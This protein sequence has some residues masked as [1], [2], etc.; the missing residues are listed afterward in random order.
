MFDL[1]WLPR[2]HAYVILQKCD[3][4]TLL[5][6]QAPRPANDMSLLDEMSKRLEAKEA[7]V[8]RLRVLNDEAGSGMHMDEAGQ[9]TQAF[10]VQYTSVILQ[11]KVRT[12]L[13]H[14][15]D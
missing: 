11:L 10:Q 15:H 5:L 7:L 1:E 4:V 9:Q 8:E 6:H 3:T 12:E 14:T 13:T 2:C